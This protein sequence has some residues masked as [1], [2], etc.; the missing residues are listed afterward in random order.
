MESN[1]HCGYVAILGRPNVGKSTLLNHMVGQK[2]SIV[3]HK[4]QTTR[5]NIYGVKTQGDYQ[6]IFIDTPGIHRRDSSHELNR[7]MNQVAQSIIFDVNLILFLVDAKYWTQEDEL[8]LKK[9]SQASCPIVLVVNKIDEI[10]KK[11]EL[12]PILDKLSKKGSFA[13]IV[14]ISAQSQQSVEVL[15]K[16]IFHYMPKGPFLFSEDEKTDRKENFR[17]AEV[18][19][20]KLFLQV[21]QEVPYRAK[22]VT[23]KIEQER[24]LK[25]IY[26]VI[27]VE[28]PSQ[29]AIIIG[30]GAEKIKQIGRAARL[31]LEKQY[32]CKVFLKLWVKTKEDWMSDS[33]SILKTRGF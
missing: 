26:A 19:R 6:A 4:R 15:E 5:D 3:T 28:K 32:G 24:Q 7:V 33:S 22:V 21:H 14:P 9:I 27:F 16:A 31:D 12:L 11:D 17:V 18:I 25:K 8:V 23:E 1:T 30:Q 29:K 13:E 2:I 20:E 10:K